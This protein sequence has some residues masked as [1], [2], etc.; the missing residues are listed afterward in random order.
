MTA[1]ERQ[2]RDDSRRKTIGSAGGPISPSASGARSARTIR[3]T[4][5]AGTISPT[6]MP[7]AAPTAGARTACSASRDRECRLCFALALWNGKRPDS[8]GAPLRP[9]RTR[10][11]PRRGREG[12]LLLPR[13]HADAFLHEGALQ[14]SAGARFRTSSSSRRTAAAASDEPRVRA[15]RHR[16]LRRGPLL[17]RLR[18]VRQGRAGR[19]PASASPSPIAVRRRRRSTCCRRSGSAT[20]GRG[21]ARRRLLAK[22]TTASSAAARSAAPSTPRSATLPFRVDDRRTAEPELL[23][24]ENETNVERLFGAPNRAARTSRTPS[25]TTS[26]TAHRRGESRGHG[27]QGGGATT[28]SNVPAGG[29]D[30]RCGSACSTRASGRERSASAE[31]R[32]DLRHSASREA[33]EFYAS[34]HPAEAIARRARSSRGRPT[35][36]CSGPSSS[37]T[38][39]SRDWL[40]GDPAQ[41]A[42]AGERQHGPQRRL[43][44]PLQPRRHL[45][46]RQV[47]VP[48]VRGVGP[49]VPHAP[50]RALDPDFAKEQLVLLLREWYMHPNGQIPA[51]EFAFGDVNP[52]VHAW[53]CWRV[54]KIDRAARPARP[55]ASSSASSRSCCS[56]SPGGS[57]AR[58]CSGNI[59]RRRL[60]RPGQH[61]RLRPLQAAAD[62][63]PARA[64]RRHR[65]DGL[66]LHDHARDG[67]GAGARTTRPTRISPPSSSSTSSPS[68][69]R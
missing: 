44:A 57:T 37:T 24:T 9:D 43:A 29:P 64:G 55:C 60:P 40:E 16:H 52:P 21:A 67:A 41:P 61:R 8:Q 69:T 42:A 56:T 4:A 25:T 39:S 53:A 47:G 68:P 3:P 28:C 59:F 34:V 35:P 58:T 62:G 20:P 12:V 38:T 33:D 36:G 27:H 51:Y 6:T 15:R 31:L 26:S 18:R 50:V 5:S 32:R 11:Q 66:L 14:V 19:H 48:V 13:L 7:A 1:E 30:R 10:G 54:Y 65:L 45:D 23:F 49:R 46:A 2:L 17:R 22:P 63:R